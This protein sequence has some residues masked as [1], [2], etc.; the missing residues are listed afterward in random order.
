MKYYK[1]NLFHPSKAP[2]Q[3]FDP[4]LDFDVRPRSARSPLNSRHINY[5]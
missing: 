1:L 3:S 5:S 2:A 4:T